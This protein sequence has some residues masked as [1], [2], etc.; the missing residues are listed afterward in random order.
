MLLENSCVRLRRFHGHRPE[1]RGI[2]VDKDRWT[3][4]AHTKTGRTGVRIGSDRTLLNQ[5]ASQD[6]RSLLPLLLP[7]PLQQGQ[8]R[9]HRQR[10]QGQQLQQ[11]QQRHG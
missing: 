3:S 8:G 11:V 1:G 10:R 5:R 7:L 6:R 2:P 9:Q 4:R